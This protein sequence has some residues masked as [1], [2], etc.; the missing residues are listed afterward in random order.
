MKSLDE[1]LMARVQFGP[2]CWVWMG[3]LGAGGYGTIRICRGETERTHR[4]SWRLANG[5]IPEGM[6]VCHSCDNRACV[7]PGHLFL[8]SRLD[9][10]R[11]RHQKNRSRGPK[12][13]AHGNAV[14]TAEKVRAIRASSETVNALTKAYGC[15]RGCIRHILARRTW[16]HV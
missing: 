16:A 11:D 13:E 8:G 6:C 7:N 2:G 5:P 1:R 9:N 12:G 14:M 4:L 15:S 3:G 10:N